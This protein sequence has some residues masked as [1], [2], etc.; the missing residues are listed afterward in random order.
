M[1]TDMIQFS[2]IGWGNRPGRS[3]VWKLSIVVTLLCSLVLS[4]SVSQA[5]TA[6]WDDYLDFA[7]VFSSSDQAD[8]TKRLDGYSTQIGMPLDAYV[9]RTVEDREAKGG[10]DSGQTRKCEQKIAP[11]Y[12]QQTYT[13]QTT[14]I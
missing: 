8:L 2:E 13:D 1:G 9:K 6:S 12:R 10:E 5:Q 4:A 7:Y 11:D 3:S 14:R